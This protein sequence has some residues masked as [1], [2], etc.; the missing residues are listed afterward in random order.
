MT[1]VGKILVFL[2]LVFSLVVGAFAVIDYT[3]RTHWKDAYEKVAAQ[4][5]VLQNTS[6][7]YREASDRLSKGEEEYLEKLHAMRVQAAPAAKDDPG[8]KQRMAQLV[9][10]EL[11]ARSKTIS[12]QNTQLESLRKQLSDEKGRMAQY[13]SAE[14]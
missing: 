5:T 12:D 13:R 2:N 3:A 1:T 14:E 7:V 8:A 9:L 6:R 11:A 10:D 4:N